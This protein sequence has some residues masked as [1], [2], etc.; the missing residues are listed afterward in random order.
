MRVMN[1]L[2]WCVSLLDDS[3]PREVMIE[4]TTTCNYSCIHCFRNTMFNEEP[5]IM[6]YGLFRSIINDLVESGVRKV[7]FSGWG[8]PLTHPKIVEM[9]KDAKDFGLYVTLNTN[10]YMLNK[11]AEDLC[12]VGVDE[13]VVSIDSVETDIYKV[14]RVGGTLSEVVSGILRINEF[15]SYNVRPLL[16]MIFTI[17][18]LNLDD[19]GKVPLFAKKLGISRIIYSHTIPLSIEYEREIAV[20]SKEELVRKLSNVFSMLSKE[21]LAIGGTISIPNSKLVVSRACPFILNNAVFVRWDGYVTPCINY[22]HNWKYVFM[23]VKRVINAVKFGNLRYE[24]LIDI[25]RKPNYLAF[26]ARTAFFIQP[27]CLDCELAP[28]CTYTVSNLHDCHGNSPTC[29]HCPY[30]HDMV[31]CPL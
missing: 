12:R 24:R 28:Y 13:I 2:E 26:R 14:I 4:V 18:S 1:Y 6:D 31:R 3:K 11:F 15:K 20:Y 5:G 30:S 7:V 29:A 27:S 8:E 9:I 19:A 22:S 21:I 25:W 23:G 16:S 17:N 10:G